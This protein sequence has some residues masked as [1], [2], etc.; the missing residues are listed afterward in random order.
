MSETVNQWIKKQFFPRNDLDKQLILQEIMKDFDENKVYEEQE[1]NS[2]IKKY[3]ED[4]ATIRRELINF[5]YMQRNERSEYKVI[6]K[7]LSEKALQ[8]LGQKPEKDG[9]TG[10]FLSSTSTATFIY[11]NLIFRGYRG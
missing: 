3:Y 9:K 4:F 6:K 5:G 2:I 8:K 7:K 10:C 1:V 11:Q